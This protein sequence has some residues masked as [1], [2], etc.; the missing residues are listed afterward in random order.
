MIKDLPLVYKYLCGYL[1]HNMSFP[2][3]LAGCFY[4]EA[5]KYLTMNA[6]CPCK[7]VPKPLQNNDLADK[8][9]IFISKL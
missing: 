7:I 9:D 1:K 2:F 8:I 6:F 4:E 3:I 5:Q